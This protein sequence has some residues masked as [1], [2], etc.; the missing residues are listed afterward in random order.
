MSEFVARGNFASSELERY[1]QRWNLASLGNDTLGCIEENDR[2]RK[3]HLTLIAWSYQMFV[4][5]RCNVF[6]ADTLHVV[7]LVLALIG[8][9]IYLQSILFRLSAWD[10]K[11]WVRV[12]SSNS[13]Q[14]GNS[15]TPRL[16]HHLAEQASHVLISKQ[17]LAE[18]SELWARAKGGFT[19]WEVRIRRAGQQA[20]ASGRFV[21]VCVSWYILQN[22]IWG[23]SHSSTREQGLCLKN[24]VHNWKGFIVLDK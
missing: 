1:A 10:S 18:F 21:F 11:A 8:L 6:V 9:F 3:S 17:H 13:L 19:C 2:M 16:L 4:A 12:F 14:L 23:M 22:F 24:S 15:K 20:V 5:I 7:I